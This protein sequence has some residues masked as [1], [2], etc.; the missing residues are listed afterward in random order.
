M[1]IARVH[2]NV[3]VMDDVQNLSYVKAART[4][5]VAAFA[6]ATDAGRRVQ[7]EPATTDLSAMQTPANAKNLNNAKT[8]TNALVNESASEINAESPV[9]TMPNV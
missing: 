4:V 7:L 8:M 6:N 1:M 3:L 2:A 5:I 9:E